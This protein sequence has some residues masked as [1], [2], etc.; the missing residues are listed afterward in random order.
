MAILHLGANRILGSSV[1]SVA[2]YSQTTRTSQRDFSDVSGYRALIETGNGLI[3]KTITKVEVYIGKATQ[4]TSNG[5]G[6]LTVKFRDA[7][8]SSYTTMGTLDT[9]TVTSTTAVLHAFDDSSFTIEANDWLEVEW[10][11]GSVGGNSFRPAVYVDASGA[12]NI[13]GDQRI[14]NTSAGWTDDGS[15]HLAWIASSNTDEKATLLTGGYGS[16][17]TLHV[18]NNTGNA[19]HIATSSSFEANGVFVNSSANDALVDAE[20]QSVSFYLKGSSLTGTITCSVYN[21]DGSLIGAIGT[22]DISGLTTSWQKITFSGTDRV[23]PEDGFLQFHGFGSSAIKINGIATTGTVF[24]ACRT[25]SL[26]GT[27]VKLNEGVNCEIV[28]KPVASLLEENTIFI[29]KDTKKQYFLQD[30]VWEYSGDAPNGISGLYAWY[31]AND[32]STITFSS[33]N[34]ISKWANKEGTTARDLIQSNGGYQPVLLS[35]QRNNKDVVDMADSNDSMYTTGG[36]ITLAMPITICAVAKMP[37]NDSAQ[38]FLWSEYGSAP[39]FEKNN[40]SNTFNFTFG[41]NIQWTSGSSAVGNY[42]DFTC[43]A[44]GSSSSMRYNNTEVATGTATG[45]F[46]LFAIGNHGGMRGGTGGGSINGSTSWREE[47]C[48]IV[49]FNKVL[50]ASELTT[51]HNYLKAKWDL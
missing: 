8:A 35:S 41:N 5:S 36:A 10:G 13:S 16:D 14:G 24:E 46:D 3:G 6:T 25:A 12:S 39:S 26:N 18:N 44:N 51:M 27:P 48:E 17:T 47:I 30:N 19:Y 45:S 22:Y 37:S 34:V 33:S 7:S 15:N 2:E 9:S 29:E 20:I 50:S 11:T 21:A 4:S 42:V 28:Y 1:N 31:D 32:S 38:H 43:I 23:L 40:S 49:I